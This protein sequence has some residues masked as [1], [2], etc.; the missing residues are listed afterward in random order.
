MKKALIF[1]VLLCGLFLSAQDEKQSTEIVA[2]NKKATTFFYTQ[3]DSAYV[4]FNKVYDIA[5]KNNDSKNLI[6]TLFSLTGVANYHRDMKTMG[7]NLEKL[8][9][10]L[11]TEKKGHTNFSSTDDYNIFLYFRGAYHFQLSEDSDARKAFEE[12]ILNVNNKADSLQSKTLQSL[13]SV[14]HS[15]LGKIYLSERKFD[16]AKQLYNKNIREILASENLDQEAL[17]GNFN[18]LAEV[19]MYEKKYDEASTYWIK[20]L[21]YNQQKNNS[22][23]VI[24]NSFYVAQNFNQLNQRD[25]ALYYL[26]YAKS[27]LNDNP[28]FYPKY[29]I[30]KSDIFA[31]NEEY[32]AS[33][34]ELEKAVDKIQNTTGN[35]RSLF[36]ASTYIEMG[37]I[38]DLNGDPE[39]ALSNYRYA[40]KQFKKVGNRSIN[41]LKLLKNKAHTLN[42]IHEP[43]YFLA[44]LETVDEAIHLLNDLKPTFKSQQDKLLL[45]EDAFPI[46]ESGLEAIYTLHAS[47]ADD[48]LID[49]AFYYLEKS[50][51]VLLLEALLNAKATEFANIPHEVLERESQLKSKITFIEKKLNTSKTGNFELEGELF[52]L[53]NDHLNLIQKIESNYPAYYNLKYGTKVISLTKTQDLLEKDELLISFFYGNNAI[54]A[55]SIENNTKKIIRLPIDSEFETSITKIYRMLSNP[56]SDAMALGRTTYAIYEQLLAPFLKSTNQKKVIIMADGLLNYIPFAALNTNPEGINYLAESHAIS[57]VNS[58]TLLSELRQRQPK[59]HTV[60]AFAPSFDGTVNVSNADRGK[61][62]PLPSNKKEVEQI[63]SSFDGRSYIDEDASLLNFKS[64]LSSFGM[65]HLATHAIFDDTAP[66]YSYLAFSQ[67]GNPTEDLLYVADLYNLKIDADLVTLSAC[68]SGLG[69]LK[70]GEGFMSLARGFFYSGAASIA[71]TLW[72][73]ND[74]SSATLMG[75]FYKNLSK[76]DAKDV[77][78]QKS[79]LHFLNTNRD[80][81]LSHPYY[82]SGF[83]ISGNTLPLSLSFN[84]V[85][86]SIGAIVILVGGLFYFRRR[87]T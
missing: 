30:L 36:L 79:Q 23:A 44:S 84:W 70:R 60:L 22:N 57:Y 62:L 2:L 50:K 26:E 86:T 11:V 58:A 61:L 3:K 42:G 59:E 10:L 83:V 24:A 32:D 67:N 46:I 40:E 9:S 39:K 25:S 18:L 45:I 35:T 6:Q 66:E 65:V 69:D 64:Q 5:K 55:I 54:Y 73:V 87:R 16:L 75:S 48:S 85:W 19:L 72:K 1:T 28:V 43:K 52:V 41:E 12:I 7:A 8:D 82:W 77:A 14:A 80:N 37:K 33:L 56:K 53:K 21:K 29:H 38:N 15:F 49:K 47:K 17:H 76:G 78:L 81:G 74:A 51:S 4:Y 34:T 20:T 13:T 27:V 63:L 31:K 71:S 68:E